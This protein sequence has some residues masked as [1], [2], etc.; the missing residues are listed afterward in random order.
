MR[1]TRLKWKKDKRKMKTPIEKSAR[2]RDM[3]CQI[4]NK[5]PS[6]L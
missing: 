2:E 3:H 1:I 5:V 4:H 6:Y